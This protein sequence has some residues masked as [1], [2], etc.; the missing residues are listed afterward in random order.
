MPLTPSNKKSFFPS[1]SVRANPTRF[2]LSL[3]DWGEEYDKDR[4]V[5]E[6]AGGAG[7]PGMDEDDE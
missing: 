5:D 1:R 6:V 3:D 7:T 4:E 2:T